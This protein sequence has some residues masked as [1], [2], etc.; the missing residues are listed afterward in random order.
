MSFLANLGGLE[1]PISGPNII[2]PGLKVA[3]FGKI[4]FPIFSPYH[5]YWPFSQLV[6]GRHAI[7]FVQMGHILLCIMLR[8]FRWTCFSSTILFLLAIRHICLFSLRFWTFWICIE[9]WNYVI[10]LR[11]AV[12]L[13][14]ESPINIFIIYIQSYKPSYQAKNRTYTI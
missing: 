4:N 1:A 13:V 6:G 11:T 10:A 3:K 12:F 8:Y 7:Y 5:A 14:I 9:S 2:I